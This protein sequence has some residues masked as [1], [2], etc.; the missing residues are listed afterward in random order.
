MK[1]V[2]HCKDFVAYFSLHMYV[3]ADTCIAMS[4]E[5]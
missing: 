2:D 5:M 4:V 1:N 3:Y